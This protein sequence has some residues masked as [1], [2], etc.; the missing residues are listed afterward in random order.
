M[1]PKNLIALEIWSSILLLIIRDFGNRAHNYGIAKI[2]LQM[3]MCKSVQEL[4]AV[5]SDLPVKEGQYLNDP[6]KYQVF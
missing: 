6:V 3:K 2:Y 5:A 4:P 1:Y